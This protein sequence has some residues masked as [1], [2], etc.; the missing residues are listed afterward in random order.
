MFPVFQRTFDDAVSLS[1]LGAC[2]LVELFLAAHDR[3][4]HLDIP[5]FI[6][7]RNWH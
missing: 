7:H 4:S 1:F 2:A 6:I 3:Y 5:T